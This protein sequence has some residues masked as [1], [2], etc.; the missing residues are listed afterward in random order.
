MLSCVPLILGCCTCSRCRRSP[1]EGNSLHLPGEDRKHVGDEREGFSIKHSRN[2]S[3]R[4]SERLEEREER[5]VSKAG[6]RDG[7]V[8]FR[9]R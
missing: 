4:G 1:E 3:E 9:V 2:D 6:K 7:K 8:Q 5:E